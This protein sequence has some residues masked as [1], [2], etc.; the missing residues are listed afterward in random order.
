M[1]DEPGRCEVCP[2]LTEPDALLEELRHHAREVVE[3]ATPQAMRRLRVILDR[4]DPDAELQEFVREVALTIVDGRQC[5][6]ELDEL[7]GFVC[8]C[9][10]GGPPHELDAEEN[11]ESLATLVVRAKALY[12]GR[13]R[14]GRIPPSGGAPDATAR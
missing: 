12:D 2:T 10:S 3:A 8:P 6:P 7:H 13:G 11:A 14:F 4:V 9:R 5:D 1:T